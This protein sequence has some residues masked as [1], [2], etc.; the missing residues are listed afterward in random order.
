MPKTQ[1]N[2]PNCKQPV[3]VEVQ[4]LFDITQDPLSKQK[5]LT[6]AVNFLHCP[7]CGYQGMVG[8]PIVYHDPEKE[9]LLTFFPPDLNTPVNEQEK[10]IGPLINQVI[11][12]LPQEKRKAYLLQ[13]QTM[14]TYQTLL[15]KIL[16]AD[17]ITKEMIEDQQNK[18]KLL[19]RLLS[20]QKPDRLEI[21]KQEQDQMDVVFFT[22]LSRIVQSTM[23][24]GDEKAQKEL[25][26]LQQ[27][28]FENTEV[29]KTIFAQAKETE[30]AIKSLQEASKDGLTREK[31][32]E[33]VI[34]AN[35]E[36]QTSM[37][38]SLAR[39]GMDY[40]FFQLLSDK[41]EEAKDE[42]EKEKLTKLRDDVLNLTEEYD[43]RIQEEITKSKDLLEKILNAEN[44]EEELLRNADSINEFF[45]QVLESELSLA[46]KKSDLERITQLEKVM[47]ILEQASTKPEEVEFLESLLEYDETADFEKAMAS[48]KEKITENFMSILNNVIVQSENQ[49]SQPELLNKLK[50][51]NKIA[52]R[53]SMQAKFQQ[54]S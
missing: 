9:L 18:V 50:Q 44:I 33:V 28:L 51:I 1:T 43:K 53:Q 8:L 42:T 38:V 20:I 14:L 21:I 48:N 32:L 30:S 15:E 46:R 12:N 29:G 2:C 6:N 54:G 22:I 25:L 45:T 47:V 19:E 34:N 52:L 11:N 17:G 13:P 27:D 49:G 41:I 4:Q 7:T 31:L 10:K 37:I 5:L 23:A 26:D 16:E 36:I 24:Q 39:A 35:S 40:L 3:A